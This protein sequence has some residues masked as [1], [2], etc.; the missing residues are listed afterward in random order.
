ME[1]ILEAISRYMMKD[2][3]MIGGSSTLVIKYVGERTHS[4][5]PSQAANLG[6][7]VV[8]LR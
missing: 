5:S 2:E 6:A 7:M 3:K 8:T 4:S 1:L